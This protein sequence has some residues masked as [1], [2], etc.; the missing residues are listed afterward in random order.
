MGKKQWEIFLLKKKNSQLLMF[1]S[2]LQSCFCLG[3]SGNLR[4]FIIVLKQCCF[5]RHQVRKLY[6]E[7][8]TNTENL[9]SE[10]R[11]LY[12]GLVAGLIVLEIGYVLKML[13]ILEWNTRKQLITHLGSLSLWLERQSGQRIDSLG[14]G[15]LL[16]SMQP[17]LCR[18][19]SHLTESREKEQ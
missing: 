13:H 5:L 4:L 12:G 2:G 9:D 11:V 6:L 17:L 8:Q 7:A 15:L 3:E 1:S 14:E 16:W 18:T 10:S 19:D